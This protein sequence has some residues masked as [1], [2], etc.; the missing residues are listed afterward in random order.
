MAAFSLMG[1][2]L[3]I[4]GVILKLHKNGVMGKPPI[5]KA[6]FLISKLTFFTSCGLCIMQA[7]KVKFIYTDVPDYISWIGAVLII[8]G[9]IFEMFSFMS[10]GS[11][12]KFGLPEEKTSLK[13]KGLYKISRNPIYLGFFIICAGSLL[14]YPNLI[15]GFLIIVSVYLHYRITLAEEK[16]LEKTFSEEW[17][18]YKKKVRRYI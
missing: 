13:T 16:F 6:W 15:N 7:I 3:F 18:S 8:T 17:I 4:Q 9:C 12:L 1:I 11:A 5:G 14:Y 10:L 2:A